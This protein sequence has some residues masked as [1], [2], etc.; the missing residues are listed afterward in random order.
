MVFHRFSV[1]YLII[2][3]SAVLTGLCFTWYNVGFA[4]LFTVIPF[5]YVLLRD[6]E[7]EKNP[8]RFY[9]YG[10]V[11]GAFFYASIFYWFIYQYPLDYLGLSK[12]EAVGFVF[13]TCIGTGLLL[14]VILA[15]WPFLTVLFIRSR[16]CREHGWLFIPFTACLYVLTEFAFTLGPFAV[17]WAKLAV[18]WQSNIF[19]IQ[20][21]SLFGSYFISFIIIVINAS[22]AYGLY[23]LFSHK[24]KRALPVCAAVSAALF[25]SNMGVGAILYRADERITDELPKYTASALQG[26]MISGKANPGVDATADLF[27]SMAKDEIEAC[28][29]KLIVMPEGCFA[30]DVDKDPQLLQKLKDFSAQ[31]DVI[32]IFGCYEHTS[33]GKFYNST[34]CVS[35]DGSMT[36]PYR[37]QHPVPFGEFTPGKE[38]I[39]KVLP[40]LE[41]LTEIGGDLDAG[42]ESTVFDS[43]LGKAGSFICFDSAFEQIGF[44]QT[45][46]GATVLT[47]STNDSWWYDSAQLY[48]HNG[49]AILRAVEGRRYVV[50]SSS[51]GYSTVIDSRGNILAGV[52]ALTAGLATADVAGRSDLSFYHKTPY[53]F[54]SVSAVFALSCFAAAAVYKKRTKSAKLKK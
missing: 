23:R 46:S 41:D 36:G 54:V 30:E 15:L 43:T 22:L 17:P 8:F 20:S 53:L 40:F 47:E 19:S 45:R 7:K 50:R 5:F 21:A 44:E 18:T 2:A 16:L 29:S 11:W 9:A 42:T 37:K 4:V 26:N 33:D 32:L 52:D 25:L 24:S 28:G 13:L 10:Y 27:L 39:L 3:V 38:I 35:P 34:W 12:L 14:S 6:A 48:Q 31:N 49:H 1:S 51:A